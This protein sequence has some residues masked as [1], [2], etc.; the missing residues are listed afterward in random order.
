M[1]T[2]VFYPAV[3]S[4]IIGNF[5][6]LIITVLARIHRQECQ[7]SMPRSTVSADLIQIGVFY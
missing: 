1:P 2:R 7:K 3:G 4:A 5:Q 6:K